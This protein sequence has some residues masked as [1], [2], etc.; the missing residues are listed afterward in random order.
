MADIDNHPPYKIYSGI[1]PNVILKNV[2]NTPLNPYTL[3]HQKLSNIMHKKVLS[4][5]ELIEKFLVIQ[6]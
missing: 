4:L 6:N 5:L 1:I 3:K 2:K